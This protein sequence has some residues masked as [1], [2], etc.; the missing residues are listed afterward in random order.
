ME[1]EGKGV[2]NQARYSIWFYISLISGSGVR[3]ITFLAR[4][5]VSINNR[6]IVYR[7]KIYDMRVL[8]VRANA[9]K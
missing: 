8:Y 7:Y 6:K 2:V 1:H 9:N 3:T 4:V 5:Q